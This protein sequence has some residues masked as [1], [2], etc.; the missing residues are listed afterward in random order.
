MKKFLI[1]FSLIL[2]GVIIAGCASD[3]ENSS[4]SS[5]GDQAV[6]LL[7]TIKER[8]TLEVGVEATFPPFTFHDENDKLVGFDVEVAEAVAAELGVDINFTETKWD[9]LIAGLDVN[10]Y[11]IIFS[12]VAVTEERQEKYDFSE[13]YAYAR[14]TI[15]IRSDEDSINSFEDISGKKSSQTITSNYARVVESYGGEVIGT[16][17]FSE[18]IELLL[19]GVVDA[20]VND[21]VIYYDYL[22]Q[23][24]DAELKIVDE[25]GEPVAT[26]AIFNQNNPELKAAVDSALQKLRDEGTLSEIS[27]KYFGSDITK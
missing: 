21:D 17:G 22:N 20:T 23:H 8:G 16:G 2:T 15:I 14:P 9:S 1:V 13:P 6:N 19:N 26:A 12:N 3:S 27:Q 11:D 25:Q 7:D 10:H 18:S 5:S 4:D 24:P